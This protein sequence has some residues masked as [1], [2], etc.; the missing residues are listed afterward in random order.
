MSEIEPF[1]FECNGD[2]MRF[3]VDGDRVKRERIYVD[4][5]SG[6]R[7]WITEYPIDARDIPGIRALLARDTRRVG[8]FARTIEKARDYA[9]KLDDL[10]DETKRCAELDALQSEWDA[11]PGETEGGDVR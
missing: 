2:Q 7:S 1:E 9:F 8:V 5:K 6:K 3:M 11:A 4:P 10:N